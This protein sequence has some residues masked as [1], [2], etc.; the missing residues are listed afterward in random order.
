MIAAPAV[1]PRVPLNCCSSRLPGPE[2]AA[3]PPLTAMLVFLAA[4][5]VHYPMRCQIVH[6]QIVQFR[7]SVQAI[8]SADSETSTLVVGAN[9]LASARGIVELAIPR[10]GKGGVGDP[11]PGDRLLAELEVGAGDL[12]GGVVALVEQLLHGL[13][14]GLPESGQDRFWIL[15]Q[16]HLV[17]VDQG[18]Q[19]GGIPPRIFSLADRVLGGASCSDDLLQ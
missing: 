8:C 6:R 7:R 2:L 17:F 1:G 19:R 18:R 3:S 4:G 9:G 12:A 11:G 16:L 5:G 10:R 13:S 15:L 14:G